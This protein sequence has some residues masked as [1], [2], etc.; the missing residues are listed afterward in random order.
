MTDYTDLRTVMVDCQVRPSDVT[1]FPIIEAMLAIPREVFVPSDKREVAY[2]GDHVDLGGGRVV[3]DP[4]VLAKMLD[5][6]DIKPDEL[7]LEIGCGLGYGTAVMARMAEAVIAVEEDEN[8]VREAEAN[9]VSQS[10]DNAYVVQGELA[11]GAAKHGPY[12][13]A[14]FSGSVEQVPDAIADQLKDGGRIVAVF[15]DNMAGSCMLG[16]KTGRKI[17]WRT[18]FDA[19]APILPGFRKSQ[20][21][22]L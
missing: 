11:K 2:A 13:L 16:I 14:V 19:T 20:E 15:A 7:V 21:F 5:I 18:M 17:A 3:F 9:L 8:L 6:V 4:R 22:I 1:K 12:D 10:A